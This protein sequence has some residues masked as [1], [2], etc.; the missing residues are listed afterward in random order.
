MG[1]F[2]V[3]ISPVVD[4]WFRF[5]KTLRR[6]SFFEIPIKYRIAKIL[7]LYRNLKRGHMFTRSIYIV[8]HIKE[9]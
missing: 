8:L 1:V 2:L 4:F 6:S 5:Y 3:S 9:V 7:F